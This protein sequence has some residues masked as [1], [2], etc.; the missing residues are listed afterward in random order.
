M[1]QP[2][3][4]LNLELLP[5][6]AR[7]AVRELLSGEGGEGTGELSPDVLEAL[8][9]DSPLLPPR[10][11]MGARF[12]SYF[13]RHQLLLLLAC[14]LALW[15]IVSVPVHLG[16]SELRLG[17]VA[18][19][20][21]VAP[22]NDYAFDREETIKR[23]D[24]AAA[25]VPPAY[26]SNPSALGQA[27]AELPEIA[28]TARFVARA[29]VTQAQ[30]S[31]AFT[32]A[33]T[34]VSPPIKSA[35]PSPAP[36]PFPLE[37][38][39][40]Q[41]AGWKAPETVIK[42]LASVS[43]SRF[44][45]LLRDTQD[46]VSEVYVNERI[47]SD[48]P[49]DA[50]AVRPFLAKQLARVKGLSAGE[51]QTALALG[52]RAARFPNSVVNEASTERTRRESR[53]AVAPVYQK[54]EAN[55]TIIREGERISPDRYA[56]LQELG[57]ASPRIK[58]LD[59]L[60]NGMLCLMLVAS[61]SF[62]LARR[63]RDLLA[64]PAALWLVACVPVVFLLLFRV[65][66]RVPHADFLMIPLAAT[67]AMLVTVLLD[68]RVGLPI[69]F[70]IAALCALMAR[71]DAGLFLGATLSAWIGALSVA[72]LSSRLALARASC[73]LAVTNALLALS[74]GVLRNAPP[75]EIIST[76]A[77]S[78]LAGLASVAA[79]AASAI[80]L[81]RPFG[82]TSHL[83]LLELIAPDET[84]I[85]RMQVE[86]PGT[87]THSLM[88]ATL[89]EA[90]AKAIGADSL[91]CRVAGL[92]HDIG[93]LRRPHCFIENQSGDNIHDRISPAL[94]AL[95][96][97][98]HVKDGL[99]LGR[100]LRLPQPVLD[101]I[102][103]HHGKGTIAFFLARAKAVAG[104]SKVDE[105]LFSYPG[106]RPQT[107]EAAILMLA[108]SVEASARSLSSPTP[109]VLAA[110]IE[111]IVSMRLREGE[112][113]ECDLSLKDIGLV[114]EAFANT[115]RGAMHGRIAYPDAAHLQGELA[116]PASDWVRQT[117]GEDVRRSSTSEPERTRPEKN[118]NPGP[119]RSTNR[120]TNGSGA[121]P[122]RTRGQLRR[123]LRAGSPP[124]LVN[125]KE[126]PPASPDIAANESED[127]PR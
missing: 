1:N 107:R 114:R 79:M 18:P 60:A 102:S 86:A 54:I 103:S 92:Y 82:I 4:P 56:L 80:F 115:L 52:A 17:G 37:T 95:L 42:T 23:R 113:D 44:E 8:A 27:Q 5:G 104:D 33:K 68:A 121:T 66:L 32:R 116:A 125:E 25:T 10:E 91:L 122:A 112:L 70:V 110:H 24:R 19:R 3:K 85:R 99:E 2:D 61:A 26:D 98:A 93:K 45:A 76:A 78:T 36:T 81:E 47:R 57:L 7:E 46:A 22:Q 40:F 15:A 21:I 55:S 127:T 126:T 96:I 83:R 51:R 109:D 72:N 59:L 88:V 35:T 97:K 48:V 124:V 90:A 30:G 101:A 58:P 117:L 14:F 20:D 100:A 39:F 43:S 11:P 28:Q 53:D 9:V 12:A 16:D 106:P 31:A 41:R 123:R 65:I 38:L 71:A 111:S 64:R 50:L 94:S 120:E 119:A 77:W 6:G 74:L 105:R 73:V 87:Y 69:G 34:T 118:K 13:G 84:V 67:A 62:Y 75:D 29:V 63:R 108:D 89:S 49:D